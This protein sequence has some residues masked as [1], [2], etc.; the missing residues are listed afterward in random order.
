MIFWMRTLT[1]DPGKDWG[2]G[3]GAVEAGSPVRKGAVTLRE[4]AG[5]MGTERRGEKQE[6]FQG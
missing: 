5:M 6:T 3:Q 2:A 1:A 4:V